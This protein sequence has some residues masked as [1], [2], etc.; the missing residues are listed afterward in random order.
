MSTP[1]PTHFEPVTKGPEPPRRSRLAISAVAATVAL[2]GVGT[3]MAWPA[4][5]SSDGDVHPATPAVRAAV[6]LDATTLEE[7]TLGE[8]ADELASLG[9]EITI[10]PDGRGLE[11]EWDVDEDAWDDEAGE[12]L[13]DDDEFDDDEFDDG[14]WDEGDWDEEDEAP[15]SSFSVR[16]D[17]LDTAGVDPQ[18]ADRANAI[19]ERFVQLIPA[20]QRTMVSDFELLSEEYG[21]AHVYPSDADP[22]RWVLGVGEGLGSDLDDILIHE[23]G[24]LLTLQ[25]REIPPESAGSDCQTFEIDEGCAL[26]ASTINRFAQK[27]W[28]ADMRAELAAIEE[29]VDDDEYYDLMDEFWRRHQDDFVTDYA[30]TDPVEDLAETF[31]VFVTGDR[32][33]GSTVADQKILLLWEDPQLVELRDQIRANLG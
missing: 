18:L 4:S 23:F 3:A 16:G 24:H 32:P 11:V 29:T 19:W 31:T 13:F 20:D 9:L 5:A 27:F 2:A 6:G 12:E 28:P 22:S 7:T 1:D 8:L 30:A 10:S 25:A 21:G 33:D 26:Q 17:R 14:E 15:L